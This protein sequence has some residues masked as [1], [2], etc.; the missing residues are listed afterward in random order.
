[1]FANTPKTIIL[2]SGSTSSVEMAQFSNVVIH[3]GTF[4][5]AQGDLHIH[6]KDSGMHDFRSVHPYR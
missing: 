1:M 5:S 3:G 4:N 6:N 2:K